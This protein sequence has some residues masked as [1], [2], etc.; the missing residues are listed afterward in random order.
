MVIGADQY[1]DIT[2]NGDTARVSSK[3]EDHPLEMTMRKNGERWQ[4]VGVTDEQLATDIARKIGQEIIA[5][6]STGGAKNA[7]NKFGVGNLSELLK[8]AEELVR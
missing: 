1:L 7:V 5:I 2:V 4:I 8:Q 6:A 3:L